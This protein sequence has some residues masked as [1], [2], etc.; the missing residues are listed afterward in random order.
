MLESKESI[1]KRL[2]K[3]LTYFDSVLMGFLATI[4]A[5]VMME[6]GG[7][8]V[9]R[10][11]TVKR[12][13]WNWKTLRNIKFVNRDT[14]IEAMDGLPMFIGVRLMLAILW[15]QGPATVKYCQRTAD[16][17]VGLFMPGK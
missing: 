2:G 16:I 3:S 17:L 11:F 12:V 10:I 14:V 15:R 1:K 8:I 6:W 9:I 13:I 5:E 7:I 4:E